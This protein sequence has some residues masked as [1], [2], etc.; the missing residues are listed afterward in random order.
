MAE[1]WTM[2][3]VLVEIMRPHPDMPLKVVGEFLGPF[4]S[5]APAIFADTVAKL[6]HSAGIIGGVGKDDFGEVVLNRLKRDGVNCE[7]VLLVGEKPT[8]VAF[9]TYFKDGSRK[10]IFHIDGT[11]ATATRNLPARHIPRADFFHIMGCSL[12]INEKFR[13][14]I[15]KNTEAF[16]QKGAKISF[17]PN[18]R[19]EL[20]KDKNIQELL[21]P[22][23]QYCSIIFPGIEE[24]YMITGKES[25]PEG[26]KELFKN[27]LIKLIVLK[28]GKE[29]CTIYSREEMINVP[30]FL[31]QEIDPTGA[32]DCFDAAFLCA[33]AEDKSLY[34]C[35]RKASAAAALN[36]IKFGP[37]EGIMNKTIL[38]KFIQKNE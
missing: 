11:S 4:P 7:N 3:E 10:F 16:F 25:I 1:I 19:K 30:A 27:N 31:I 8:A 2:G 5:G 23:M 26:I 33:L 20:L 15:L 32:G 29:G 6:G 34:D 36:T 12:M 17:D 22:I 37:M 21:K 28:K 9:V 24:L 35:G 38:E 13:T 18:I 14:A